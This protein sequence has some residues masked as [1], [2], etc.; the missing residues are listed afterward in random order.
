MSKKLLVANYSQITKVA[1]KLGFYF[2]RM[3]KGSHEIWRRDK[4]SRQTTIPN[5]GSE[6]LKKKTFKSIL[7]DFGI[8]VENFWKVL[9]PPKWEK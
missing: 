7:K 3:A 1:K 4:D 9:K 6:P 8:S 5:H 2:C